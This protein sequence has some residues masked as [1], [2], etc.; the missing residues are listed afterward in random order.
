M[1][2]SHTEARVASGFFNFVLSKQ[3]QNLLFKTKSCVLSQGPALAQQ[4]DTF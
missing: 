3:Q 2:I 4:P 1:K